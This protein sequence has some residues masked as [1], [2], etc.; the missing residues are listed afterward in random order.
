MVQFHSSL[1][2]RSSVWLE[3]RPVTPEA[4]GSSPVAPETFYKLDVM[5]NKKILIVDDNK[6]NIKILEKIISTHTKYQ[7]FSARSGKEAIDIVKTEK[8][9]LIF[10]DMMMPDVDG[11]E[12]TRQIKD[13]PDRADVPVIAVTAVDSKGLIKDVF[14]CG[15]E[16]ILPKPIDVATVV[17]IIKNYTLED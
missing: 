3:R 15:C 9:A 11:Y 4:A 2:G 6:I 14:A 7:T 12:A 10:M 8:P 1:W 16:D 17:S 5:E 13:Q